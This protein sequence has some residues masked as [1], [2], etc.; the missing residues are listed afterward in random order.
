M[1]VGAAV[2]QAQQ[3]I[4]QPTQ[5]QQVSWDVVR[6]P[7]GEV[8]FSMPRKPVQEVRT[9]RGTA[10]PLDLLSYSCKFEA[11]DYLLQRIKSTV[12]IAPGSVPAQLDYLTKLYLV[13]NARL[14][15]ESSI[16]VDGVI[17]DDITYT[18]PAPKGSGTIT[19]RTRHFVTDNYY[20]A[21]TVGSQPDKPLPPEA[22]RFLSSLTFEGIVKAQN[23]R[24]RQ[25]PAAKRK[26]EPSP[27]GPRGSR[28]PAGTADRPTQRK[29][30]K[31]AN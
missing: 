1:L 8:A 7:D 15:K 13:E 5:P 25:A 31:P 6:A 23:N 18:V 11:C 30:K 27:V 19:K 29:T 2:P 28:S 20:Y 21:L 12:S 16:V 4:S 9:T 14:L 24:S 26:I 17:G 22:G 3:A 10:G